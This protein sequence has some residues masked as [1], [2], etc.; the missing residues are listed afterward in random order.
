MEGTDKQMHDLLAAMGAPCIGKPSEMV[1]ECALALI[2]G[3]SR[4]AAIQGSH[5][6]FFADIVAL[7]LRTTADKVESLGC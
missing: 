5:G 6:A 1:I 7:R 2:V 3:A 4:S